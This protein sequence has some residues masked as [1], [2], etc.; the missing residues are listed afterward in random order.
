MMFQ[1]SGYHTEAAGS[2][3][4]VY[5]VA[6]SGKTVT[7]FIDPHESSGS[8]ADAFAKTALDIAKTIRFTN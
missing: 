3:V 6:A 1:D 5:V 2:P 4:Q 7:I 8:A